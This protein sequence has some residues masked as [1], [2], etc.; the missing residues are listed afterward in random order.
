MVILI[1]HKF[2][3][4][5]QFKELKQDLKGSNLSAYAASSRKNLK[6]QWEAFLLF[7]FYFNL[8]HLPAETYTLQLYA[9]FLSRS[10]KSVDSI[11]NYL[12]GVRTMHLLLGYT[13]DHFN[14]FLI[15]L[16]LKGLT[17]LKQHCIKQAEPITPLILSKIHGSLNMDNPDDT[18]FWC[19][20]L[21]AFF[22]VARTSNLVPTKK[23]DIETN[24]CLLRSDISAI[25]E[26]LCVSMR[27]SKQ[28]RLVRGFYKHLF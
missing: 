18:V 6:V 22:L 4:D 10:F 28:Y 17:R 1:Y 24:F 14:N 16:S 11:R 7:C 20:F 9:Q 15:N 23:S 26:N 25:G 8:Q 2:I 21:L 13:S 5:D 12:S 3:S 27:W 19:L